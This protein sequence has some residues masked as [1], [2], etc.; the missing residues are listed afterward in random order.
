MISRGALLHFHRHLFLAAA[1]AAILNFIAFYPGILHHDAWAYFA[2]AR[3]GEFTNWQ[4]PLLG[5]M[6]I[7]LQAI[8]NGPQPMLVL[9]MAGY[10]SGFVLI[11]RAYEVEGGKLAAC[12]FAAGLFPLALNFNGQLVKDVSM[13]VCL[14]LAAGCAAALVRGAIK[15]RAAIV[16]AMWLFL[17]MGAFMR[18]NALF[19][20]PPLLDLA[21]IATSPYWAK[22]GWIKRAITVCLISLAFAPGHIFADRNIFRVRDLFPMSQL[23]IFDIGGITYFSGIDRFQGFFG[24]DFAAKNR[25]CYEPKAW[26]VYGWGG[27]EEVYEDLQPQFG[28]PLT[29]MWLAALAADPISYLEHRVAH[30]NRFLEFLCHDCKEMIYTGSQSTNQNEFTFEPTFIYRAIDWA[31]EAINDSPFGRPYVWLLICLAW[32]LAAFGIPN[33]TTRRITL[34]MTASGALYALAFAV[35][36]IAS[37]YRYIYWTMLCALIATPAVVARVIMRR[38]A[39]AWLRFGPLAGIFI[40]IVLR[41]IAVRAMP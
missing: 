21:G 37:D 29:K 41:E 38:D 7:P 10:W 32:S 27:C 12:T 11:A 39:P 20:L 24:P 14:L 6:W 2:A 33:P 15:W 13:A 25:T 3:S 4:P 23:Q 36:G 17:V 26:D 18:A 35:V 5:K 22:T 28:W 8:W 40:L 19:A 30:I 9:F 16:G 1:L 31:S 34:S